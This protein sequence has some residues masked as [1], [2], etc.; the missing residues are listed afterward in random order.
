MRLAAFI[1]VV[2]ALI[3]VPSATSLSAA[4]PK[5]AF[6]DA[7]NPSCAVRFAGM[8][9]HNNRIDFAFSNSSDRTIQNIEFGAALYDS[10][11]QLHRVQVVGDVHKQLRAGQQAKYDL[12]IKPWK[13]T[14]YAAWMLYPSKVLF[15]D[16]TS[17]E[18][19]PE[20]ASCQVEQWLKQPS[21]SPAT[22]LQALDQA[23]ELGAGN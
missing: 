13:K 1:P 4:Q 7:Q 23:P 22:P 6:L 11:E 12:D 20:H 8:S 2:I 14:G 5:P 19:T 16:G 15:T 10:N 9:V 21:R 3:A 18:M 17:W